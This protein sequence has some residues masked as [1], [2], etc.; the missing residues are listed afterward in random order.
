MNA[1]KRWDENGEKLKMENFRNVRWFLLSSFYFHKFFFSSFWFNFR[2]A[3]NVP[4]SHLIHSMKNGFKNNFHF[5]HIIHWLVG[6]VLF[7][8]RNAIDMKT[9]ETRF[10][11]ESATIFFVFCSQKKKHQLKFPLFA[12]SFHLMKQ[13]FHVLWWCTKRKLSFFPS[14]R[15][16]DNDWEWKVLSFAV[17]Q[18]VSRL[19]HN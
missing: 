18:S 9:R 5:L 7:L 4:S 16:R 15:M 1:S 19:M 13:Y 2:Y 12:L 3:D 17:N 6:F 14:W 8:P 11:V 10:I